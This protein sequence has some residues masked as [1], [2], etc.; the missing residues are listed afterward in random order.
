MNIFHK[1]LSALLK[2]PLLY[3]YRVLEFQITPPYEFSGNLSLAE[4]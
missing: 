1:V 4:C 2:H 3:V